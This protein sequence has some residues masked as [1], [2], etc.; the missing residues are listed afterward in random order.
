MGKTV[1]KGNFEWDEDKN[2]ANIRKHGIAF[3]EILPM[4]DDPL[5]WEQYDEAHSEESEARYFGM[6]RIG[7]FVVLVSSY[8]DRGRIRIISARV[9]T[10]EEQRRYE[11]W[12]RQ[13]YSRE[14]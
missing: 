2:E 6:G 3:E 10:K 8:V 13:F 14:D 5:F 9:S 7:G 1:V 4:F 11:R 12:C